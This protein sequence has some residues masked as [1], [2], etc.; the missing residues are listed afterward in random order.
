M[1]FKQLTNDGLYRE[2]QSV[3]I[4]VSLQRIVLVVLD[5]II[6]HIRRKK[7]YS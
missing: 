5:P 7:D 1:S 4:E 2:E 3:L 6:D